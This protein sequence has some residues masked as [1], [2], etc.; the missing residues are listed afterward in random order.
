MSKH[1]KVSSKPTFPI[2]FEREPQ[3]RP[4]PEPGPSTLTDERVLTLYT[5][6]SSCSNNFY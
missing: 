1:I 3:D 5:Q 6:K 4:L 2:T